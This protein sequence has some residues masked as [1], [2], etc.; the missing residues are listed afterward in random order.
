LRREV[1]QNGSGS[2]VGI[3]AIL[4][5]EENIKVSFKYVALLRML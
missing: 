1:D 2:G 4:T 3:L 5:W